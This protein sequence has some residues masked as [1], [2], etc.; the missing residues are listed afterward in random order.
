MGI[1]QKIRSLYCG[2]PGGGAFQYALDPAGRAYLP[3]R[4][5]PFELEDVFTR[6][7]DGL[8]DEQQS[9]LFHLVDGAPV[10]VAVDAWDGF[11]RWM[12]ATLRAAQP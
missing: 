3:L 4:A 7:A 6:W 10:G 11:I 1:D 8:P 5:I 9:G 2:M 12:L